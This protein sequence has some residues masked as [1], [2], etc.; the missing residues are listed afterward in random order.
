[1]DGRGLFLPDPRMSAALYGESGA[2]VD[3]AV[4]DCMS[5][6]G[7]TTRLANYFAVCTPND[8]QTFIFLAALLSDYMHQLN[9]ASLAQQASLV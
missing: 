8:E 9:Q 2:P 6:F 5:S 1:M 4:I 3:D 7:T